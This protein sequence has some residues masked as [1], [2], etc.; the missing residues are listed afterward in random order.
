MLLV[1]FNGIRERNGK[2]CFF[3]QISME[4]ILYRDNWLVAAKLVYAHFLVLHFFQSDP[5]Q[6]VRNFFDKKSFY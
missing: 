1:S 6:H 3:G 5:P 4:K 2:L